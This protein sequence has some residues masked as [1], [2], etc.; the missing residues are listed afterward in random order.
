[1]RA[2]I[3]ENGKVTN[4]A[5]FESLEDAIAFYSDSGVT[6]VDAT[7]IYCD[8]GWSYTDGGFFPPQIEVSLED[9]IAL[10]QKSMQ[11][12]AQSLLEQAV[13]GYSN[14]ERDTWTVKDAE[15]IA[16]LSSGNPNDAHYLSIE[17]SAAGITLEAIATI[18]SEKAAMLKTYTSH[19]LGNRSYHYREIAISITTEDALGYDY[20]TGWNFV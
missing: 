18:V 13:A 14:E 9:A 6:A 15:A 10:T 12:F 11:D 20:S 3:V 16:F 1:M 2:A 19:V 7:G 4:F 5:E 17:A 8:R